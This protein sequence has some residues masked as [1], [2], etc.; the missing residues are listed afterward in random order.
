MWSF[1]IKLS[2]LMKF[3]L[4]VTADLRQPT[5]PCPNSAALCFRVVSSLELFRTSTDKWFL[6]S[7]LIDTWH[8][9]VFFYGRASLHVSFPVSGKHLAGALWNLLEQSLCLHSV[10]LIVWWMY[11]VF[12]CCQSFSSG[13]LQR[14]SVLHLHLETSRIN[15][16]GQ[17]QYRLVKVENQLILE[18]FFTV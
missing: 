6:S 7:L 2:F 16:C 17:R 1:D 13:A 11:F 10:L 3:F 4:R 18:V 8:L 9:K 15:P 5:R 12:T 14:F